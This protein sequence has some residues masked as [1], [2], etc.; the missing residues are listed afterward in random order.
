[1]WVLALLQRVARSLT[2][3]SFRLQLLMTP[4]ISPAMT[5]VSHPTPG[6]TFQPLPMA[7]PSAGGDFFSPLT[8]PAL[9]P[10]QFERGMSLHHNPHHSYIGTMSPHLLAQRSTPNSPLI[11]G[12]MGP[13]GSSK[14][15]S[16]TSRAAR[17]PPSVGLDGLNGGKALTNRS[18]TRPSPIIKPV[19]GNGQPRR[20][21]TINGPSGIS[22]GGGSSAVGSPKTI[23]S[24]PAGQD[25]PQPSPSS[26]SHVS[27]QGLPASAIPM[28]VSLSY[29][30]IQQSVSPASSAAS[31][32]ALHVP[33]GPGHM[34]GHS[35][36]AS[37]HT[38]ATDS[39][40]S[41]IDFASMQMPPPPHPSQKAELAQALQP[42]QSGQVA[43]Q[44]PATFLNLGHPAADQRAIY[45][46][47]NTVSPGIVVDPTA[48][49]GSGSASASSAASNSSGSGSKPQLAVAAGMNGSLGGPSWQPTKQAVRIV[50]KSPLGSPALR[51]TD[52]GESVV[53]KGKGRE[54]LIPIAKPRKLG[55][56]AP[57][58]ATAI[59]ACVRPG[60]LLM[61]FRAH[62]P[63]T[64]TAG[65]LKRATKGA[66]PQVAAS[67]DPPH[68]PETKKTSHKAA[69]QKRRDSLKAGFDELRLL[70]PPINVELVDPDTGLPIA[71]ASMPRL[72]AR[73]LNTG[74][75]NRNVSKVAL[76]RCSNKHLTVLNGRIA[77]R[78]EWISRLVDNIRQL[79]A[80]T[81]LEGSFEGDDLLFGY[82]V[83]AVDRED[84]FG[85]IN[86]DD[87]MDE[88]DELSGLRR[89]SDEQEDGEGDGEGLEPV[90]EEGPEDVIDGGPA[91]VA[92][93]APP[94]VAL[95]RKKSLT[96]TGSVAS[97]S[98][99]SSTDRA[100]A[101]QA[102][103]N[104]RTAADAELDHD[105][106]ES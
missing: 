84:D 21:S 98:R 58:G 49:A 43:P 77:R 76:L 26:Q 65:T 36:S 23:M 37:Q 71:G 68:K 67:S 6:S 102:S 85:P 7:H 54:M 10:S 4:L 60:R 96:K 79:R 44:T 20:R 93:P 95:T 101:T 73:N 46:E 62:H 41:P 22:S 27:F 63:A 48:A 33:N 61:V 94:A 19:V 92:V 16:G 80:A 39:S 42:Q 56:A 12:S 74:E 72:P 103:G 89:M 31:G 51:P 40:P 91:A 32:P 104:L 13:S 90:A 87:G 99:R 29:G 11:N 3:C 1:M 82:D 64:P 45:S 24:P 5:A 9:G 100:S 15:R 47:G 75:P 17:G 78:D 105:M 2:P 35:K 97:V 14:S 59:N 34:P 86:G 25:G 53:D 88:D 38:F 106:D 55:K 57:T 52:A 8:S 66:K 30:S 70:L 28:E 18:K 50:G 81:G 83:D 69:E